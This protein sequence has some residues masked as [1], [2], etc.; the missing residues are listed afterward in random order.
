MQN[1]SIQLKPQDLR[2]LEQYLRDFDVDIPVQQK[3]LHRK[4]IRIAKHP[5]LLGRELAVALALERWELG[6]V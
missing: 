4:S 2:Q 6:A 5:L 1:S 3:W